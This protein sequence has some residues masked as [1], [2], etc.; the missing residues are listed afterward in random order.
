M[1]FGVTAVDLLCRG[2]VGTL[3]FLRVGTAIEAIVRAPVGFVFGLLTAPALVALAAVRAPKSVVR[4]AGGGV[5]VGC[6]LI[7]MPSSLTVRR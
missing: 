1:A 5:S 7:G 4:L 3:G 6:S 2:L